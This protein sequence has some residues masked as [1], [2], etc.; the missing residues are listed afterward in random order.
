MDMFTCPTLALGRVD[1]FIQVSAIKAQA[2]RRAT[3]PGISTPV[4]W[5]KAYGLIPR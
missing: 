2:W 3:P 5:R 1:E 4:L